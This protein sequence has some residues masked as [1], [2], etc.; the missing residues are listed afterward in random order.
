MSHVYA[1]V[2]VTAFK[3]PVFSLCA[4][5]FNLLKPKTYIMYRQLYNSEIMCSAHNTFMCFVW[6]WEQTAIISLYTINL[7]VFK[8]EAECFLRGR[9]WVFKSDRHSFVLKVLILY[10]AKKHYAL[11]YVQK[12]KLHCVEERRIR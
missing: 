1:S 10:G 8:I 12:Q 7:S 5:R 2:K 6:V 9:N 3:N 4:T 11:R